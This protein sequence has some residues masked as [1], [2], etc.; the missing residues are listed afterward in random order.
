M[1][2]NYESFQFLGEF[3]MIGV[4]S[5][6]IIGILPKIIRR[7]SKKD[8]SN[9]TQWIMPAVMVLYI[10]HYIVLAWLEGFPE[11]N[12]ILAITSFFLI[13]LVFYYLIIA[14]SK[15]KKNFYY[16]NRPKR[17]NY[18]DLS[19]IISDSKYEGVAI[20][21]RLLKTSNM[22]LFLDKTEIEKT[23]T[24]DEILLNNEITVERSSKENIIYIS[25]IAFVISAVE[26]LNISVLLY[27]FLK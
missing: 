9:N 12:S 6:I 20:S 15:K 16:I 23:E 24:M 4:Y 22:V 26:F 7:I 10:G 25:I 14:V 17:K 18:E 13:I 11:E 8:Y 5:I 27:I 19:E 3:T 1:L 2:I 21:G